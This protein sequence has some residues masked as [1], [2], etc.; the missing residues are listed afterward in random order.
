[1]NWIVGI[2]EVGR[3]PLAGP[4]AV[5][6]VMIPE[7]L[8]L[9]ALLPEL[10]DSKKL[11]EKKRQKI[12]ESVVLYKDEIRFSVKFSSA[13]LIDSD[14]IVP[15][16]QSAMNEALEELS[17]VPEEATVYL[18]GGL[19]APAYYRQ[20]TIIGGDSK[21][22]AIMLASVMAKVTRDLF[23]TTLSA[24]YPAYGFEKH[25]GYGTRAHITAIQANGLS[26]VHRKSFCRNICVGE[27]L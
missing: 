8:D 20:E 5:G 13:T 23:M 21:V 22:S 15:A 7:R 6:V 3:G 25:K 18:D 26:D 1:M 14:G 16:I 9:A 17:I 11:S 2:D 24:Q 10:D 27:D 12:F 19:R 4:V